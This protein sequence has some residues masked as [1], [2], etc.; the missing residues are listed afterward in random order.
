MVVGAEFGEGKRPNQGQNTPQEPQQQNRPGVLHSQQLV[1]QTGKYART[2]H[3]G[4][5]KSEGG[6]PRNFVERFG[7]GER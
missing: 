1:A 5:D 6:K 2:D 7:H 3:V 4:N